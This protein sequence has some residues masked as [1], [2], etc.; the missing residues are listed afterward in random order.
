MDT[1]D[2][3]W[4]KEACSSRGRPQP[5]DRSDREHRHHRRR[6]EGRRVHRAG[7]G[8]GGRD[9][10]H[11][12]VLRTSTGCEQLIALMVDQVY[13]DMAYTDI[14]SIGPG[15]DWQPC[16]RRSSPTILHCCR[17]S[18]AHRP[19]PSYTRS[20]VA[21]SP[22]VR[23]RADGR[24]IAAVFR[25]RQGRGPDAGTGLRPDPV[26][27]PRRPPTS[28]PRSYRRNSL[29]QVRPNAFPIAARMVTAQAGKAGPRV[30]LRRDPHRHRDDERRD[31][32]PLR[33]GR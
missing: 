23:A 28:T 4:R 33:P 27:R 13:P 29:N 22:E 18:L 26:P 16:C 21:R 31:H 8:G 19:G 6:R 11:V 9:S 17:A 24:R 15:D 10:G 2:L 7:C 30:R 14:T 25:H 12:A 1:I 5:Y 20:R 32:P 3:L